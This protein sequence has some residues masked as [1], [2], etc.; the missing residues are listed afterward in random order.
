[1]APVCNQHCA[2]FTSLFFFSGFGTGN[3]CSAIKNCTAAFLKWLYTNSTRSYLPLTKPSIMLS[4]IFEAFSKLRSRYRSLLLPIT[5]YLR[6]FV[7]LLR[8]F[9]QL[10]LSKHYLLLNCLLYFSA[11]RLLAVLITLALKAPAKPRF[12]DTTT[13]NTRTGS[14]SCK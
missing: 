4:V 11:I 14:R 10:Q 3:N 5:L 8:F 12:D 13:T 1:M 7:K 6:A 2:A 9:Y